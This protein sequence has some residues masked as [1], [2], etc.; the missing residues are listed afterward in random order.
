MPRDIVALGL[1]KSAEHPDLDPRPKRS[2]ADKGKSALKMAIWAYFILLIFEGALRKW[3]LP[4]LAAPLLVVR[5]PV[6]LFILVGSIIQGVFRFDFYVSTMWAVAVTAFAATMFFGHGN[7]VVAL[8]GFRILVLQFPLIF[9][10]GKLFDRN[11]VIKMGKVLLWIALPMTI[12]ITLQ[13][14]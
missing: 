5:D 12:L 4:S 11:D 10:I 2:A 6:A 9:L 8:Y 14:Y 13:F 3:G 7:A 1:S